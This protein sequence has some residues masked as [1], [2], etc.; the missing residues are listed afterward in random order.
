M[1]YLKLEH[2]INWTRKKLYE[3][4]DIEEVKKIILNKLFGED[5]KKIEFNI[6]QL[7]IFFYFVRIYIGEDS[8]KIF[9]IDDYML[10]HIPELQESIINHE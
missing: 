7:K 4:K 9:Y 5:N 10:K 1:F 8:E 2:I 6:I 3:V